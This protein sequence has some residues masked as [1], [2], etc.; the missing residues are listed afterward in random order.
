MVGTLLPASALPDSVCSL[1]AEKWIETTTDKNGKKT[2][3]VIQNEFYC[4]AVLIAPDT[5]LSAAHC[6][7]DQIS[8]IKEQDEKGRINTIRIEGSIKLTCGKTPNASTTRIVETSNAFANPLFR[9]DPQMPFTKVDK[10]FDVSVWK[11]STPITTLAPIPVVASNTRILDI[12][13]ASSPEKRCK[14]FGYGTTNNNTSGKLNGALTPITA[15]GNRI[16]ISDLLPA[17]DGIKVTGGSAAPGDSGGALICTAPD[18]KEELVG[19]VS[20]GRFDFAPHSEHMTMLSVYSLP[21]FNQTWIDLARTHTTGITSA[22]EDA[23]IL[24][25]CLEMKDDAK[26]AMQRYSRELSEK[27]LLAEF[28]KAHAV[29]SQR[30][31][32][33]KIT[34]DDLFQIYD[35]LY[36][37]EQQSI[38]I[39]Q[40]YL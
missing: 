38:R 14:S 37:I 30:L 29:E 19:I 26:K 12:V 39:G 20:R 5:L 1:H 15:F 4:S 10:T 24:S 16:I 33:N 17:D 2:E 31:E 8:R 13:R 9:I 6:H 21:T 3:K 32:Q 40:G 34:R 22:M 25:K 7:P 36:Y 27:D 35:R 23:Y 18:G 28:T 11:L